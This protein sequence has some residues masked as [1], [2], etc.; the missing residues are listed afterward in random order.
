MANREIAA[1]QAAARSLEALVPAQKGRL[2]NGLVAQFG[3]EQSEWESAVGFLLDAV[4]GRIGTRAGAMV[5]ASE[6]HELELGDDPAARAARDAA[7]E[8]LYG[9]T[10]ELRNLVVALFGTPGVRALRL[11]GTTP[12]Q[13]DALLDTARNA[14]AAMRAPQSLPSPNLGASWDAASIAQHIE[15]LAATLSQALDQVATE[16]RQATKTQT[17]K[18]AALASY[19]QAFGPS[20]R[21]LEALFDAAGEPELARRVRPSARRPGRLVA[22]DTDPDQPP[23]TEAES[24]E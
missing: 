21:L 2:L 11:E 23:Q 12:Q 22:Q 7:F 8:A 15:A 24:G 18:D 1:R 19:D 4:V 20:A 13:P 9:A 17:E 14:V 16:V 10:V 6:A 3:G 5:A